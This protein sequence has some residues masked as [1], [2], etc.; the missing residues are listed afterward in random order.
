MLG[1]PPE[2]A[3][4]APGSAARS[5]SDSKLGRLKEE[6]H[7]TPQETLAVARAASAEVVPVTN[8]TPAQVQVSPEEARRAREEAAQLQAA[9]AAAQEALQTAREAARREAALLQTKAEAA[10]AEAARARAELAQ[11]QP[12][13][14]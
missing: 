3:P 11:V 2:S 1:P 6:L 8:Q 7:A 13:M 10:Q 9:L 5:A 14:P 12:L 4:P